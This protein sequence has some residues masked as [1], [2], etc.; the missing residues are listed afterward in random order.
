M[1][2]SILLVTVFGLLACGDNSD[3]TFDAAKSVNTVEGWTAFLKDNPD[4]HRRFEARKLQA[5]LA[6]ANASEQDTVEAWAVV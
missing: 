1:K 6:F 5:N 3:A 2:F 4:H